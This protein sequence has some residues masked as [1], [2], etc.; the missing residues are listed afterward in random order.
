MLGAYNKGLGHFVAQLPQIDGSLNALE[1]SGL[2]ILLKSK[3]SS[4]QKSQKYGCRKCS[5]DALTLACSIPTLQII[6]QVHMGAKD[7]TCWC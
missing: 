3:V 4:S 6:G 7:L 2:S 5:F 1:G